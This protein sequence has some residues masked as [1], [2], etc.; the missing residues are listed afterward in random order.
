MDGMD[1]YR[2][3][4]ANSYVD[5]DR[6]QRDLCQVFAKLMTYNTLFLIVIILIEIPNFDKSVLWTGREN[7]LRNRDRYATYLLSMD[8]LGKERLDVLPVCV[9]IIS[10]KYKVIQPPF[11]FRNNRDV[12]IRWRRGQIYH[13]MLFF[14]LKYHLIARNILYFI[15]FK[16]V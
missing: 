1:L 7:G 6:M 15:V 5:S 13:T 11:S 8:S 16:L 4:K 2:F 3:F 14:F 10:I 12:A 9:P